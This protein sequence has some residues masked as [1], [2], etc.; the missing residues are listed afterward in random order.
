MKGKDK[1]WGVPATARDIKFEFTTKAGEAIT[2]DILAKEGDD[3]EELATYINGQTDKISASVDQDESVAGFV[4]EPHIEG[5][6]NI[7]GALATEVGLS[8]GPGQLTTVRDIDVTTAGGA[9]M[10]GDC[11]FGA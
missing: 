1:N 7:S 6:L 2:L 5:N 10:G 8:G 11:R 3:I 4:A 9:Q